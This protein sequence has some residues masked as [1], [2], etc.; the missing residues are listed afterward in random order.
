[1]NNLIDVRE[2]NKLIKEQF[3]IPAYQ[4]G[5]RWDEKQVTELLDD[6]WEFI[7]KEKKKGEFYCLQPIVV[8]RRDDKCELNRWSTASNYHFSYIKVFR[9]KKLLY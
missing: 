7:N 1:M 2:I 9:E 6:L 8:I 5:Y 3:I 4:R